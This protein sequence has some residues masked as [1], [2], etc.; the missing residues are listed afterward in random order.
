MQLN[1][2]DLKDISYK[3]KEF[4]NRIKMW[5][6][7]EL[8]KNLYLNAKFGPQ[9]NSL[10]RNYLNLKPLYLKTKGKLP[11]ALASLY[12]NV[13][14]NRFKINNK[15]ESIIKKLV[16]DGYYVQ[17]NFLSDIEIENIKSELVKQKF[18][19]PG[20]SINSVSYNE[21]LEYEKLKGKDRYFDNIFVTE[22]NSHPISKSSCIHKLL[23]NPFFEEIA[24][25]YLGS[26][27][28]INFMRVVV[29]KAKDP[30]YFTDQQIHLSANKFHFDYSHLRSI[31]FFIYLT[32]VSEDAGPHT[33]IRS[34][35]EENFKYPESSDDFYKPGFRK[36]YNGTSEGLLKEDWVNKN[37][38]NG[39]QIKFTGKKGSLI[40]EDTTGFHKG[41]HCLKGSREILLL[42]YAISNIGN[43]KSNMLPLMEDT[44]NI[45]Q[46][47][48]NFS[49]T[50][51]Y[52]KDSE[53]IL[54][55]IQNISI[56]RK[57][58]KKLLARSKNYLV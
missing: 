57:I 44:D 40:I 31:R 2:L 33:F 9:I 29:S 48:V 24:N 11:K 13:S 50:Q 16:K 3:R 39:S 20:N 46:N 52:R 19:P 28:F 55:S 21:L 10:S 43:A 7:H 14:K 8:F 32:D 42:N 12:S 45:S 4:E 38:S 53:N 47:D 37:F 49:F 27:S 15:F 17:E 58:K 26:K 25:N 36:Y 51:K 34:S 35:H 18:S 56:L 54:P 22:M 6:D 30:R 41:A 23:A 1:N 5:V